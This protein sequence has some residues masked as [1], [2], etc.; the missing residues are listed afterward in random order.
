MLVA[1]GYNF[2]CVKKH[3][4]C[5]TVP[6]LFVHDC[7]NLFLDQKT[8]FL[9]FLNGENVFFGGFQVSYHMRSRFGRC[10]VFYNGLFVGV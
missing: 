1:R 7:L 6:R 5:T 8:Q 4:N 3:S 2:A 9:L 10:L